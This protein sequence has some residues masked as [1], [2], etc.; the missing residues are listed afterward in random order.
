[1]NFPETYVGKKQ[2]LNDHKMFPCVHNMKCN[3]SDF[4]THLF[5]PP[6]FSKAKLF[7]EAMFL[8]FPETY[9]GSQFQKT[10]HCVTKNKYCGK[11]LAMKI[12]SSIHF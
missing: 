6:R 5:S 9:V 3:F 8:N 2:I 11:K 10:L 1:M 12:S 4:L 7:Q